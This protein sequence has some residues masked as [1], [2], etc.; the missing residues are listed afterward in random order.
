MDKV[1]L[2]WLYVNRFGRDIGGRQ[3][4]HRCA[5]M[6]GQL[7]VGASAYRKLNAVHF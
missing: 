5:Q 4:D 2:R 3:V 6:V 7:A 1:E